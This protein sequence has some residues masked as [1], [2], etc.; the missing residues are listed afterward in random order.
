[1]GNLS[2]CLAA[3]WRLQSAFLPFSNGIDLRFCRP[4]ESACSR[5]SESQIFFLALALA[6][7]STVVEIGIAIPHQARC[8]TVPKRA[9][10]FPLAGDC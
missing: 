1:M 8:S 10:V 7:S 2:F 6:I 5:E 3:G 9:V 4:F